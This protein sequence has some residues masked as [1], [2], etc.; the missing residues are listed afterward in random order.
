[1]SLFN[2]KGWWALLNCVQV[3]INCCRQIW[4]ANEIKF[5]KEIT[6]TINGI[7]WNNRK[8]PDVVKQLSLKN[9]Y[10]HSWICQYCCVWYRNS[11]RE[12]QM[13]NVRAK[14]LQNNFSLAPPYFGG[15]KMGVGR[16]VIFSQKIVLLFYKNQNAICKVHNL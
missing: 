13:S 11:T 3:F 5:Y 7:N 9:I 1:M 2:I 14:R 4:M 15:G 12:C 8:Q 16:L 10:T 6:G